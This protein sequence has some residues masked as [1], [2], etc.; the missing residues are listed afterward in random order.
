MTQDNFEQKL[1]EIVNKL[2]GIDERIENFRTYFKKEYGQESL[3]NYDGYLEQAKHITKE[4]KKN[5]QQF[6][7]DVYYEDGVQL[8]DKPFIQG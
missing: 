7:D 2:S 6:A 4:L 1:Q 5:L 8:K 3:D